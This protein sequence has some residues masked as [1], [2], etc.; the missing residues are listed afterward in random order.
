M[1]NRFTLN[2]GEKALVFGCRKDDMRAWLD[3]NP[4]MKE[5]VVIVEE[6]DW[7]RTNSLRGAK[8]LLFARHVSHSE[9]ERLSE[10]AKKHGV[11]FTRFFVNTGELKSFLEM[12][13]ILSPI[14]GTAEE[15]VKTGQETASAASIPATDT[16]HKAKSG[17]LK[18]FLLVNADFQTNTPMVEFNRLLKLAKEGGLGTTYKSIEVC[19]YRLRGGRLQKTADQSD[20]A[21]RPHHKDEPTRILQKYLES[22]TTFQNDS[23]LAGVALKEL[24][25]QVTSLEEKVRTLKK[26]NAA[27]CRENSELKSSFKKKLAEFAKSL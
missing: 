11:F 6:D 20:S 25:E 26:E 3:K 14:N 21:K 22:I 27:L 13:V 8:G 17:E 12:S 18:E 9:K 4:A 7:S 23:I 15:K 19:F 24:V 1:S 16:L 5:R 10:I 2:E